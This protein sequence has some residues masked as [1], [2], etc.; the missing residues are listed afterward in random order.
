[1]DGSTIH[2]TPTGTVESQNSTDTHRE[3]VTTGYTYTTL[4]NGETRTV[5][6]CV[7]GLSVTSMPYSELNWRFGNERGVGVV[8]A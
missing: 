7:C 2:A 3:L 1:M 8:G 5:D 6:L 4:R